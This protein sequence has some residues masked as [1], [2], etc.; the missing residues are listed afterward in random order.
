MKWRRNLLLSATAMWRAPQRTLL[1]VSGMAIGIAAVAVVVGLGAGAERALQ[2]TLEQLGRNLLVVSAGRTETGAL[3][4]SSRQL[5]TLGMSDW[6]AITRLPQVER[7]APIAMGT[8][9][10]RAGDRSLQATVVGS[11]AEL[12]EA[13]NFRLLAGRF[14]DHEDVRDVRRVAVLGAQVVREL[15]FGEWPIG[16]GLQVGGVPFTVIGVLESK[17]LSPA[18]TNQDDQ[19]IVPVSAAQRRLLDSE[20]LDRIFVQF[21]SNQAVGPGERDRRSLL[22]A[23][24][25]LDVSGAADDFEIQDQDALLAAQ[26]ETGGRFT[27][28]VSALAAL[29]LLLGAVGLLAVSWLSVRDRRGEI[30]LRLAVGGRRR[31]IGLQFLSEAVL[32]AVVGG[33]AGSALGAAGILLGERLSGWPLAWT[34]RS[35]VYPF[36]LS[37]AVAVVFGAYPALRAARLDPI[38]ALSSE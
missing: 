4:G 23:R 1:S 36:V 22:R 10:L 21:R 6:Q 35:A 7:A 31:D 19:I 13:R 8:A 24:H 34:W 32:I 3:R 25:A 29:A 16:G 11:T 9:D 30:G 18:G 5:R 2:Q 38:V 27:L 26:A 37:L 17:G 33:L 28:L 15:F 14:V 12:E 20:H